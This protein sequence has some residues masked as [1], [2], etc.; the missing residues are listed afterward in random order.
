MGKSKKEKP[1]KPI[2][3]MMVD[4]NLYSDKDLKNLKEI[5]QFLDES[6]IEYTKT[7]EHT[8][9]LHADHPNGGRSYQIKYAS[10]KM[11]PILHKRFNLP[12]VP[13]D[14]YY[15]L[16]H[17]AEH[18]ENSFICWAKDY[19]WGDPRKQEVL[20]SYWTY[21]AGKIKKNFYAR[22]CE[23]RVVQTREARDFESKHC[24]YGKR[25]ASLNLALFTKKEKHG[26]PKGTMI[27][28]YTFG[29]STFSKKHDEIEVIRVGTKTF[30]NVAGGASK[31]LKYFINNYE[32]MRA[33]TKDIEVKYLKFYSDYCHNIGGS[34][35]SLGFEYLGYSEGGIMNFHLDEDK[36][37]GRSPGKHKWIMEQM[38]IGKILAVPNSG[39]KS[40]LLTVDREKTPLKIAPKVE[41]FSE[42]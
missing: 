34:M 2:T 39:V 40:F 38:K 12:G 5:Q 23:V 20:K 31:L 21:A 41:D 9:V 3:E 1:Q 27:M 32:Y 35:D 26:I 25:G 24:F 8:F 33:G 19:E 7:N 16:S 15:R 37:K 28:L 29:Y 10:A 42:F 17:R 11:F 30:C 36:I 4:P 18:E 6:E 14:F 22:D 13:K